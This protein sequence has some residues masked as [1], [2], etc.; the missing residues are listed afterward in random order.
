[1]ISIVVLPSTAAEP[2]WRAVW[3]RIATTQSQKV[4]DKHQEW[5]SRIDA[6]VFLEGKKERESKA[7]W[8]VLANHEM[9]VVSVNFVV[10]KCPQECFSVTGRC[11]TCQL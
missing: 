11:I 3:T 6:G 4:A 2:N 5:S 7:V 10:Q 1:M 8:V 9:S